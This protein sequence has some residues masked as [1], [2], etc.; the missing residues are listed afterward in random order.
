MIPERFMVTGKRLDNGEIRTGWL[1]MYDNGKE[2]EA[3]IIPQNALYS[4]NHS[5]LVDPETVE[6]IAAKVV[7]DH[8]CPDCNEDVKNS[9]SEQYD[10]YDE[11]NYCPWC[12][13]RLEWTN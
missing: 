11:F 5:F 2:L 13:Q 10:Y 7:S 4:L 8:L 9:E 6:P 3:Y 12:G 1:V